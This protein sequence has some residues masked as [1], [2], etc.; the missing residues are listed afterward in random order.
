MNQIK[1][2]IIFCTILSIFISNCSNLNSTFVNDNTKRIDRYNKDGKLLK[3]YFKKY[4]SDLNY[5][6]PAECL[7]NNSK[8]NYTRLSLLQIK[9]AKE[10]ILKDNSINF[11]VKS[12]K[13]QNI[14]YNNK[15]NSTNNQAQNQDQ[16]FNISQPNEIM[17]CGGNYSN[18]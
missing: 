5:W 2:K 7:T 16:N 10:I 17:G 14:T 18:C 3:S 4:N 15:E 6:Y 13:D 11:Q 8:C 12:N 9:N 1:I